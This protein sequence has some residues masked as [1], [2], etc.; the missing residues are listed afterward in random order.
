M[1]RHFRIAYILNRTRTCSLV[2]RKK[3]EQEAVPAYDD[4]FLPFAIK[5]LLNLFPS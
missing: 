5:M 3:R 1:L 4:R 2:H